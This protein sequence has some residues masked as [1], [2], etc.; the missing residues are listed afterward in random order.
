MK[1]IEEFNGC[2]W[3]NES[4]KDYI[5]E[6]WDV[7]GLPTLYEQDDVYFEYNQNAHEWSKKSCTI[8]NAF[9]AISDLMN[10]EYVLSQIKEQDDLSY[11]KWRVK[12]YWRNTRS[13]VDLCRNRRN[14]N[15]EL[16]KQFWKVASYRIDMR[17]DDLVNKILDKNYTIC[18]T[19]QW[20]ANYL[21]DYGKDWVLDNYE[22]W[23]KTYGHSVWLRKHNGKRCIKDNYKWRKSP[24]WIY[25]NFY[26]LKPTC[27]Q[28]IDWGTY[29]MRG[30]LF[31]KVAEDNFEE[32]QRLE[33][34]KR[35]LQVAETA[36]SEIRK[37]TNDKEYQNRLHTVNEKHRKKEIDIAN[38]I[39][40][41]S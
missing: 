2:L 4:E 14:G 5:L 41:H 22:F 3:V 18:W 39:K 34:F 19:F 26:E 33:K 38:E 10:Y 9:G 36:H 20:N 15:D 27:K 37:I 40:K 29:N 17:N 12:W 21:A 25:T 32:L 7:D 30:Y 35:L 13:A 28:L 23:T 24:S 11:T 1:N 16:V 31:T 6:E 8:F